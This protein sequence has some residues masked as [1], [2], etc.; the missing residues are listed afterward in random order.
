MLHSIS[1][2]WFREANNLQCALQAAAQP[3]DQG[4]PAH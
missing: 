4:P 3:F 2:P 1:S